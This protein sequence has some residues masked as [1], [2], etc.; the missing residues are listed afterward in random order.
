MIPRCFRRGSTGEKEKTGAKVEFL[1]IRRV[2]AILGD[3]GRAGKTAET[4]GQSYVQPVAAA[5]GGR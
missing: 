4:G 1:L 2:R 3:Y 5:Q